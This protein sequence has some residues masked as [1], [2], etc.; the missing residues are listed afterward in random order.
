MCAFPV[1]HIPH[2]ASLS[3]P[4]LPRPPTPLGICSPP[5]PPSHTPETLFPSFPVLP[6]PWNVRSALGQSAPLTPPW[7][8]RYKASV[9]L[10]AGFTS[11]TLSLMVPSPSLS[12]ALKAPV[13]RKEYRPE[14]T[15]SLSLPYCDV[16]QGD[17]VLP[18]RVSPIARPP[19]ANPF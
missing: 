13:W 12:N 19:F 15:G 18:G 8:L 11:R 16:P 10:L 1:S 4:L 2:G 3:V 6:H 5:P 7:I 17:P 14:A 9:P